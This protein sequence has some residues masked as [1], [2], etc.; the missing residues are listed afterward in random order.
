MR[1]TSVLLPAASVL[2]GSALLAGASFPQP[3]G[4]APV[5]V[6]SHSAEPLGP[7][8]TYDR[9]A[10][11][12]QAGPL[13]VHVTTVDL[14]DPHVALAVAT[15]HDVI[16]GADEALSSIADRQHAEAAINADYFDINGSGAP[17]NVVAIGGR[18]LHEPDAAAAFVVGQD[19]RVT[20]GS[21][22]YEATLADAAGATLSLGAVDDW[23][24]NDG[25]SLLTPAFGADGTADLEIVL[26]PNGPASYRVASAVADPAHL[27]ALPPGGFAVVARGA[28][29]VGRLM[30]FQPG[31]VVTL[32]FSTTPASI[33]TAVG[34]GPLLLR[35][36]Q[37][38]DDPAA[39]APQEA[40]V[41][42]PVSGA[43]VSADGATLWLVAVDGRAPA[44]SVGITRSMLG[45]LLASLGA[46][47][48][49]AFDS[50]GSTEMVVRH[51]GDT[52]SSV[53]NT[54]SDGRER[55]IADA[56][57]VLNTAT[58]GPAAQALVSSAGGATAVLAGSHL[59][60]SAAAVDAA[61]QPLP[62]APGSAAYLS[63]M[64]A[65]ATVDVAGLLTAIAPGRVEVTA[66]IGSIASAPL[67][68]D[69]LAVP[70]ALAIAGYERD[71][72]SG[73][74][75]KLSVVPSLRD[76]RTV[77]VDP[78]SVRWSAT[79]DGRIAPDGSF[80]AGKLAG[81]ATVTASVAGVVATSPLLV[82]EH[83]V[84]LAAL[85]D[86]KSIAAWRFSSSP[87]SVGGSVDGAPA[88]DGTPALHLSFDFTQGGATRAAYAETALAIR[89]EPLAFVIDV[90][91]DGGGEWL[92]AGYRNADGIVDT[93]TLARH[94]DWRGWKTIR[95][96]MPL[97]ARWPIVW[98][99]IYAVEPRADAIEAGDLWFKDLRAIDAGP[100]SSAPSPGPSPSS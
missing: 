61:M 89:D 77:A 98:T 7:G 67:P 40:N 55:S 41:R 53:A 62:V 66:R 100:P 63:D 18:V 12:T 19:G 42:Y 29:E 35:G 83:E 10:L 59:L 92:R 15:H 38:V 17:L 95:V 51:L 36:G 13:V 21:V 6:V 25:I 87:K 47:D 30:P 26:A 58:P 68:I 69:V 46:S 39:P 90:Y 28:E 22:T 91:G 37:P 72:E 31:D 85:A 16:V 23:G 65:V 54:P 84:T 2:L 33:A 97:T 99:R 60:L 82:G 80:T 64:P 5:T 9:W 44:T 24:V 96:G 57:L 11:S 20:I 52:A 8:V 34:G 81:T 86:A 1:T 76:G 27:A 70:D 88:P 74:T 4:W 56:L 78:G 48:A 94:V 3:P 75:V 50:G 79:G 14:H 32:A 45:E 93:L 71:V 43:G 49:M 73:A